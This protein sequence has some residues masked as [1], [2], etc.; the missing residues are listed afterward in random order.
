[1]TGIV[2]Q[3]KGFITCRR[4]CLLHS[5]FGIGIVIG[6]RTMNI[7]KDFF[8]WLSG[9]SFQAPGQQRTVRKTKRFIDTTL[10][11]IYSCEI[12]FRYSSIF[13][14]KDAKCEPSTKRMIHID[15]KWKYQTPFT[16]H[17]FPAVIKGWL[18]ALPASASV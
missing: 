6:C 17:R 15:G 8:F 7:C 5:R 10:F 3:I 4:S 18:Q 2:A 9:L 14:K 13:P 11:M 12:S 1:M 16:G